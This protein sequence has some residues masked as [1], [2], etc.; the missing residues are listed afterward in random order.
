MVRIM[1]INKSDQ[2]SS[3]KYWN[4]IASF[5]KSSILAQAFNN[6]QTVGGYLGFTA[7]HLYT[8]VK[9]SEIIQFSYS[10]Y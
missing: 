10:G 8:Q 2:F 7:P 3:I 1:L 4:N 9:L 5:L 6:K